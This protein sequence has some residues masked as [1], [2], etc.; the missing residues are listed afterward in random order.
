MSEKWLIVYYGSACL[1]L[2]G[3]ILFK[4]SAIADFCE[5]MNE[6]EGGE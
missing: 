1:A 4:V 6:K 5:K 2:L 3:I